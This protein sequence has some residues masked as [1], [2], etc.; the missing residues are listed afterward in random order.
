MTA[1][2]QPGKG[3]ADGDFNGNSV[4]DLV[5][6]GLLKENFGRGTAGGAAAVP[7]PEAWKLSLLGVAGLGL[8]WRTRRR[9]A[10][11]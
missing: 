7:E 9:W 10:G 4:P 8:A 3:W 1:P 6:F 11:G 2:A 5:D